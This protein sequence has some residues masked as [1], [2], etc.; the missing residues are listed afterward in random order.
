MPTPKT[1][2][3]IEEFIE[4]RIKEF[5][6]EYC[7]NIANHLTIL[8][9]WRADHIRD[10]FHQSLTD[11]NSLW[12]E[13][14]EEREERL[15]CPFCNPHSGFSGSPEYFDRWKIKHEYHPSAETKS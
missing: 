3:F 1:K 10:F 8:D 9:D 15:A 2:Q 5:V 12:R 13:G 6:N 11:L 4:E 14:V 7:K